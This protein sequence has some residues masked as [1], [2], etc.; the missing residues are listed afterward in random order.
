MLSRLMTRYKAF[1]IKDFTAPVAAEQVKIMRANVDMEKMLRRD[2]NALQ[3]ETVREFGDKSDF[4]TS[5]TWD[6]TAVATL[7]RKYTTG[8]LDKEEVNG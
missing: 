5:L 4:A 8:R 1:T 3:Q 6:G 2:L 7:R